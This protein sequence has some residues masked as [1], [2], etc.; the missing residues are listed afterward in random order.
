MNINEDLMRERIQ[1]LI[2]R[3]NISQRAFA[4]KLGRQV[5]NVY[6]ILSGERGFPKGF[7]SDIMTSFPRVSKDWLLFGEGSMYEDE[8]E[9]PKEL[10]SNT[11]PR[12]PKSLSGGH[13]VDY[14]EG[15]KRS[16]CQEKPIITQLPDYDFTIILK[17]NRMSPKYDRGD[18]LAFKKSFITEW[19]NDYLLDTADGPKF[20]KIYDEKD[21]V[22]C[23]SYNKAE[24]PDFLVP[25]NFIYGYYRCV[26]VLKIL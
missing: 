13:L 2:H 22:R 20:K 19:G 3:E 7:Y 15:E 8:E 24:Y 23:V 14:Y 1:S 26:G 4:I 11:R 16:Q 12:L 5:S 17:N 10:P 21:S 25:K 18:E 9:A 6:Q